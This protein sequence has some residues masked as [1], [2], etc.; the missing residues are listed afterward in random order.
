MR[1]YFRSFTSSR[2]ARTFIS[3]RTR[4][5]NLSLYRRSRTENSRECPNLPLN[6]LVEVTSKCNLACKMCN[7]HHDDRSGITME[8]ALLEATFELARTAVVVS[9]YGLGEPLLHPRIAEI[10]EKYKS[11]GLSVG[12]TTNAMLLS[13]SMSKGLIVNGLDHLAISIDAA[14]PV[15]FSE[16][17]RGADLEKIS[18]NIM[19]LNRL[20]ASLQSK[21]PALVL[22]VV[23]Q[24][25]NFHQ[26]PQIVQ[27][28]DKWNVPFIA[29]VPVA[30]H[31]HI[32]EIQDEA[33]GPWLTH[34]KGIIERCHRE[35]EARGI[36]IDTQRVNYV[37]N[38]SDWENV[39]RETIPCPEPFR[40][41]GIRAN[42]DIFPC[43]NWDVTEPIARISTSSDL[44]LSDLERAWQSQAWQDLRERVI[45]QDYPEL[46]KSCMAKFTR[47]LLDE[48]LAQ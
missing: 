8:N 22:N 15:L 43:C 13:E 34:E 19:T 10:I 14:E 16:I 18:D 47:P 20:K 11:L 5:D 42:G 25:S 29:F 45:S 7:I 24:A 46:C 32:S 9:P 17:R 26:L 31:K 38:G 1:E 28:A 37:L 30:T 39:Y 44:S 41:M 40:F 33:L 21:N 35:A 48:Y 4:E 12:L 23:V 3:V 27:L 36:S 2:K 6:L